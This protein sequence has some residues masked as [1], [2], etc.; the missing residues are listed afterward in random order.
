MEVVCASSGNRGGG[1]P[2]ESEGDLVKLADE[3]CEELKMLIVVTL[4][5]SEDSEK[6]Q[7][8]AEDRARPVTRDE[9]A[10]LDHIDEMEAMGAAIRAAA[11]SISPGTNA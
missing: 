6:D 10:F 1:G 9:R 4:M 8:K 7:S 11:K 2:A 3:A 5:A